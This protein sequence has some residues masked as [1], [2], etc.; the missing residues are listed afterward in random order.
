M[1]SRV[2]MRDVA[3]ITSLGQLSDEAVCAGIALLKHKSKYSQRVHVLS[4]R[5]L[6]CMFYI[7]KDVTGVDR[8][9]S[10]LDV[11]LT[12][13]IIF[14][15]CEAKHW[16]FFMVELAKGEISIF[17][18]LHRRLGG[19]RLRLVKAFMLRRFGWVP[20][21]RALT[22]GIMPR[23]DDS[24]GK[25][26][27]MFLLGMIRCIIEDKEPDFDQ[28]SIKAARETVVRELRLALVL[29]FSF[30]SHSCSYSTLILIFPCTLKLTLTITT[31]EG[32]GQEHCDD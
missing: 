3:T 5:V 11:G 10:S 25:D 30:Y 14:P 8:M 29:P 7:G 19:L 24:N 20:K 2:L 21:H 15:T 9:C 27:G 16:T 18:S 6:Q 26:C 1:L 23:Q 32:Q 12:E 31:I 13:K 22:L 28:G 4:P 17:N